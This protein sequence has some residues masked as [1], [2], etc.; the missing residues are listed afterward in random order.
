M[1]ADM[2]NVCNNR[3][4]LRTSLDSVPMDTTR[5]ARN[6]GLDSRHWAILVTTFQQRVELILTDM[7]ICQTI[8][9][10]ILTEI[11]S[12]IGWAQQR[13][14]VIQIGVVVNQVALLMNFLFTLL[15]ITVSI[16]GMI[17]PVP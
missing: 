6:V 4:L 15:I 16:V 9:G 7:N 17:F 14:L 1:A 5:N 8:F 3:H 10:L 2:L 12:F 11:D 13:V